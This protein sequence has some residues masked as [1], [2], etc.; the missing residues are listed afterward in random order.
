[1]AE[2]SSSAGAATPER[3]HIRNYSN[4]C[5]AGGQCGYGVSNAA[6]CCDE[7]RRFAMFEINIDMHEIEQPQ[8]KR[9][10]PYGSDRSERHVRLRSAAKELLRKGKA[11]FVRYWTKADNGGILAC[12]GLSANDP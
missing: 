11:P 4:G 8:K 10:A 3:C 12:D 5:A 7:E 6:G 1:M 2:R 9:R